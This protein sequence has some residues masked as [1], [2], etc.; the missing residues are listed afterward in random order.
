MLAAVAAGLV[1]A[2]VADDHVW[3]HIWALAAFVL[4]MSVVSAKS[5]QSGSPKVSKWYPYTIA[6]IGV[7]GV[8]L[9]GA[10]RSMA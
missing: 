1:C 2:W 8:I 9:G 6:A 7:A 3:R 10:I 5:G 4:A